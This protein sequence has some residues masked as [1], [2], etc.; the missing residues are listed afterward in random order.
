VK[1]GSSADGARDE[2]LPRI[3]QPGFRD[4]EVHQSKETAMF[5]F[6]TKLATAAVAVVAAGALATP[7]IAGQCAAPG[8]NALANAPTMPKGVTD[9]VIGNIDLAPEIGVDGRQLRTRRLVVQPGGIVPLHSH[10]G[11]PALI[12]TLSGAIT[13]YSSTCSAPIQHKAG[14]ISREADG[15]S[16]YW[17][18]H[19]KVPA[20]LLSSDVFHG[21]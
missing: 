8:V 21:M 19:G 18:N 20:V 16:H 9:T 4:V 3:L 7:A 1:A 6:K 10:K 11:R 13:E 17:I 5:N 14:D 15:L 12:Y 2:K